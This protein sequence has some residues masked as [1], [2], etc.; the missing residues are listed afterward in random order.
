ML[1]CHNR[2]CSAVSPRSRVSDLVLL[3]STSIW[4]IVPR[5]WVSYLQ[6]SNILLLGSRNN[7]TGKCGCLL[8]LLILLC[9]CYS[10]LILATSECG[11]VLLQVR[12][13][14]SFFLIQM[15]INPTCSGNDYHDRYTSESFLECSAV[16]HGRSPVPVSERHAQR[17]RVSISHSP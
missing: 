7:I 17:I 9:R 10:R 1:V 16:D 12:L 5:V 2:W 4:L 8:F 14:N 15:L 11:E 6:F 13:V 3:S